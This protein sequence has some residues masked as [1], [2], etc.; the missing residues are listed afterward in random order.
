MDLLDTV[1]ERSRCLVLVL[2]EQA[3]PVPKP[4]EGSVVVAV[5]RR[6]DSV[7]KSVTTVDSY[8]R[9]YNVLGSFFAHSLRKVKV[10]HVL[11]RGG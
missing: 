9:R 2:V 10:V 11:G 5:G 6:S 3:L 8:C 1:N 7:S 4:R